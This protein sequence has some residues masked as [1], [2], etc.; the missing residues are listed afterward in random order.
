MKIVYYAKSDSPY[1]HDVLSPFY[2]IAFTKAN[3]A[4]MTCALQI[5]GH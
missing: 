4:T 5:Q 2:I 1:E 3:N